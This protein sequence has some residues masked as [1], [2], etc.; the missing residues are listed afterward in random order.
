MPVVSLEAI[1]DDRLWIWHYFFRMPG[2]A[3]DIKVLDA[4]P[5]SNKIVRDAYPPPIEYI[6]AGEKRSIPYW[7]ADGIY[8][9]WSCLLQT[10]S[11]PVTQK[12]RILAS[13]H[14][15]RRK[16]VER[17]FGVLQAK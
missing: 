13:C 8:P 12:E 14:G 16:D 2:C 1:A 5:L 4:S 11:Y 7:L 15:E 3:N 10:V 9:K 6:I 17:A